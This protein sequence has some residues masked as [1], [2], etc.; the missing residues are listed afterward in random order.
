MIRKYYFLSSTPG[1]LV[2]SANADAYI[3]PTLGLGVIG[4]AISIL[5]ILILSVFAFIVIPIKKRL[6]KSDKSAE[7]NDQVE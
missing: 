6:R 2:F 7:R 5:A 4:T 3:G 1:M